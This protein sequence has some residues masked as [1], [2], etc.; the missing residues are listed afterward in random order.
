MGGELEEE[1]LHAGENEQEHFQ[2]KRGIAVNFHGFREEQ[3]NAGD[4]L[5]GEGGPDPGKKAARK[6]GHAFAAHCP[7][8]K[9]Q[10]ESCGRDHEHSHAEEMH[11]FNRGKKPQGLTDTRA[12]E[13]VLEPLA[14]S[15]RVEHDYGAPSSERPSG[16]IILPR[17]M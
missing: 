6:I 13:G 10:I 4:D 16:R 15:G 7:A 9:T 8:E 14:D 12:D 17:D 11:G 3:Q 1:G 2:A 5:H